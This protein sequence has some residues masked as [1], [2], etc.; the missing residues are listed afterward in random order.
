MNQLKSIALSATLI[1]TLF[2]GCTP[3]APT[4]PAQPK[5]AAPTPPAAPAPKEKAPTPAPAAKPKPAEP[6]K[7]VELVAMG[8]N[9][10]YNASMEMWDADDKIAVWNVAEGTDPNWK[11]IGTKKVAAAPKG[12]NNAIE[13]PAPAEGQTVVMSQ[14]VLDGK[15]QPMRRLLVSAQVNSQEKESVH[16]LLTYKVGQQTETIRRVAN[17]AATW[18]TLEAQFWVPKEADTASFRI[19]FI[20]QKGVK[21]PV[22]IDDV[23]I[24]TM[25]PKGTVLPEEK[26]V[27]AP[28]VAAP[29]VAAPAVAAPVAKAEPV[30]EEPKK[31]E[32]AKDAKAADSKTATDTKK[33]ST[34]TKSDAKSTST[35]KS[36]KK[37]SK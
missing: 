28:A 34:A 19:Q 29:A 31:E 25:Y 15:V 4:A 26:P 9:Y 23:R 21:N 37:S 2:A 12:G 24:Q 27:A 3:A 13:L 11:N 36:D 30:K 33:S 35:Q 7:P 5:P 8:A 17:G 20:V 22:Q 10:L 16:M 18:D 32:A 14:T 6:A 1:A